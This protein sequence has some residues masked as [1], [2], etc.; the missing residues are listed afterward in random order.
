MSQVIRPSPYE[1]QAP[2]CIT[3]P[4][5]LTMPPLCPREGCLVRKCDAYPLEEW[6]KNYTTK[7]RVN[8][9]GVVFP[10]NLCATMCANQDNPQFLGLLGQPKHSYR[11]PGGLATAIQFYG[12]CSACV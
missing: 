8:I 6:A 12:N 3:T 10:N 11:L 7:P 1:P 2:R 4:I 9:D 5:S